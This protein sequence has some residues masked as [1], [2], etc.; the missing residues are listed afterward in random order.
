MQNVVRDTT[1]SDI[2]RNT[3]LEAYNNITGALLQAPELYSFLDNTG[4]SV[5]NLANQWI[6]VANGLATASAELE[7]WQK[8]S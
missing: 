3:A 6:N 1:E 5:N 4:E 2:A 8:N 7:I